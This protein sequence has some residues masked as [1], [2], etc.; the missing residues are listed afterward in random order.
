MGCNVD[1]QAA[2]LAFDAYV[3]AYDRDNAR[4]A[5][6]VE[7]TMRV[8]ELCERI[9]R[10]HSLAPHDVDLAWMLGLLHDIGRFE[11][12]RRFDTFNDA[13]SVSHAS[14]GVEVLFGDEADV[15]VGD[16]LIRS[17]VRSDDEDELIRA[18]I[19]HHSDYRLPSELDERT[20]LFCDILR[21]ADKIDIIRVN[22]VCPIVDIYGVSE[23]AMVV[24]EISPTCVDIF[25]EHRCLPREVRT[26]PAD[27]ML[28]HICFTWELVF[29]E[30]KSIMCEEG[31]LDQMLNRRWTNPDT[32]QAFSAMAAHMRRE[33]MPPAQHESNVS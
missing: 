11:Q 22:C 12:I 6:K 25:Y 21:D 23:Q 13:I 32:Q 24:S 26:Y 30:S 10:A 3:A 2:I 31:F 1:R 33:L 28:G 8:A 17:F 5:L 29:E 15:G 27:I 19:A 18:A 4:I 7:H 16:R 20:R 9:A 14:L